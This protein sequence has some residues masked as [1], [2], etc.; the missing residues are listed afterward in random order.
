MT[1]YRS[2]VDG[3][4]PE[5]AANRDSM[6]EK[7]S[8]IETEHGKAIAGGG[9]KYVERH[10]KRGKL[11]ARERIELL[12]DEDSPF[13]ELSPLAAWGSNYQV[14][15]SLITGIGVVEG[16]ECMIAASD[17]T[18][19]GGASNPWTAKKSYRAADIAAQN[20]LP[21]INLVE[22]GGADLPTQKEIFI[23]GGRIF[24]D[25]TRASAARCRRSR[26]SSATRRPAAR[27]CRACR[28]TSSWSRSGPRSSSAG[29]RW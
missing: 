1:T 28:T 16:V 23:P 5:F 26:W 12:I 20:R 13:L 17:P 7:L 8:E 25:L 3:R 9:E 27:T 11:M 22:S 14:G 15:A 6:L 4:G 10:R 19:K 2:T 18:V 21:M 29:R 24:R